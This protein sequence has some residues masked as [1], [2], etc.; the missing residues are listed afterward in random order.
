MHEAQLAEHGGLP[1]MRSPE[2]LESALNRPQTLA[3]Y[4]ADTDALAIGAMYAIAIA[5]NH[6]FIDGNKRVAW[7]A[8]RTFLALN[9]VTLAFERGEAVTEMLALAAGDRTDDQFTDWVRRHAA[10]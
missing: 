9:A 8:M 3:A 10:R 2:L 6:P 5:R 4:V 1:G 7:A